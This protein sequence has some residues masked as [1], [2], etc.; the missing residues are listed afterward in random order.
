[1]SGIVDPVFKQIPKNFT[2]FIIWR[3]EKLQLVP[4]PKD[5]YSQFYNGDA[6]IV[7]SASEPGQPGGLNLKVKETKGLEQHI[8]FW[9]GSDVSQDEAGVAAY[10]SVELDDFLGGAPIQHR[11]VE[12]S[13]SQRFRSYFPAGIRLLQ[14]GVASGFN[15]VSKVFNPRLFAVKGKRRPVVRQCSKISWSEMNSGDVFLLQLK[16]AVFVWEGKTSN[17]M[18]KLQA[19]KVAQQLKAETGGTATIVFVEEGNEEGLSGIEKQVFESKLP[20]KDKKLIRP[21]SELTDERQDYKISNEIKLYRCSDD[22]GTLRVTEVKTGPLLQTDLNSGDSYIV[23][24]GDQGVW[25]WIGKKA[26]PKERIEAM[27]NAQG[28]IRK[29]NYAPNT[30]VTRVIDGGEP[31]EF[32][33]LFCRWK[34]KNET[35]GLGRQNSNG[36]GI[37]QTVHT[38]FDASLLHEQPQVAAKT[39]MLDDGSGLTEVFKVHNFKLVDVPKDNQGSFFEHDCYVVKYTSSGPREHILVYYWLG[40]KATNEDRGAAALQAVALDDAVDGRAIQIRVIQGK[41]PPHFIAI[42]GGHLIVYLGDADDS[43]YEPVKPYLLQIRGGSPREARAIQ[44][45]L[46]GASLNSND[47]FLLVGKETTFLWCG[48]GSTG[49]EREVA[50]SISALTRVSSTTVYEGQEKAD[51]WDAIG[52]QEEYASDKRL[53]VEDYKDS[54]PRLFQCSNATGNLRAEEIINFS[55][56]DLVEDDVMLLDAGHTIFLWFGNDSNKEER[57][58]SV[59]L[60]QNYLRSDPSGRDVDTAILIVKQGFE[61]PTF[62]GFFGVWDRSIWSDNKTFAELKAELQSDQPVLS[63]EALE[64]AYTNGTDY[65]SAA[66]YPLDVLVEK[67]VEKLPGDVNPANKEFHLNEDDFNRVLKMDYKSFS[68]LPTWR[69][70]Q[71]KKEVG[72]F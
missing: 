34:V 49:D 12:G 71:L 44:V 38:V 24:N 62:T 54:P 53:T 59:Q 50:K 5:Q 41:E 31:E 51:F 47:V 46:R 21:A 60:A 42:F 72:L 35:V 13:E 36:R 2:T 67:D 19:A 20:L 64:S 6:Y 65:K 17:K 63:A 15:H 61:P 56:V 39:Q 68:D 18:E 58:G 70:Q 66:K 4:L 27:R 25:A 3:I 1:M 55:Q 7:Y 29:K 52:G 10:K 14:G 33:S 30:P 16:E 43:G 22:D 37:A 26:S 48:K 23:D 45:Q 28:F 32:K 9:L 8:H 69:K 57:T 40:S 11:E